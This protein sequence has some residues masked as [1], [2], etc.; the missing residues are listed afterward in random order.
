MLLSDLLNSLF[1]LMSD[2]KYEE[3]IIEALSILEG[4]P[5][6]LDVATC[7]YTIGCAKSELGDREGSLP[8]F[9][10]AL[11]TFPKSETTLI[12]HVQDE[13]SRV[14]IHLNHFN[15]ALFYI[16]QA[17]N[18][19]DKAGEMMMKSSCEKLR[20]EILWNT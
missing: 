3:S 6:P 11:F 16:E 2:N 14:Q 13:I 4:S 9:L 19:F 10:E 17:I 7:L 8:F 1:K 15:S 20:E 18:N 5:G 12:A